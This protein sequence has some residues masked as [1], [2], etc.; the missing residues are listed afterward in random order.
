MYSKKNMNHLLGEYFTPLDR[1]LTVIHRALILRHKPLSII[2]SF[3][4]YVSIILFF[5]NTLKI[6]ANY[7]IILPIIMVTLGFGLAGGLIMGLLGL[8]LNLLLF[9]FLGHPEYAPE[10][11]LIA[12]LF[13][14]TL[15][16][17]MGY[18]SD[19]FSKMNREVQRRRLTEEKLKR[20]L[21]DKEIL[22]DEVNHRVR[23]NLNIVKSLVSLQG[24]RSSDPTFREECEKL[25]ERIYSISL[26]HEQLYQQ[27]NT[28]YLGLKKY[29][30][31]LLENLMAGAGKE[32]LTLST[33]WPEG[34]MTVISDKAVYL[35]LI[36]HEVVVN[37]LK[38]AF[39]SVETPRISFELMKLGGHCRIQIKD[40]GPGFDPDKGNTG[41]G[42]KLIES[43]I[44]QMG[45]HYSIEADRGMVFTLDI[46]LIP[47]PAGV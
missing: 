40:N 37:S 20:T 3:V 44:S 14:C 21:A 34:E 46:P 24:M 4:V 28:V 17:T 36:V 45:G 6:S 18:M 27:H 43:L 26:V 15:G 41:L 1:V 7:F 12:E 19:Y 47:N 39:T 23:N 30:S 2:V 11:L 13:G 38:Y 16:C 5:G 35:G 10:S 33:A 31:V 9:H 29:L 22:L 8:P 42:M 32:D 25:K